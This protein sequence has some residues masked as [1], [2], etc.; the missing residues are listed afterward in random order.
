MNATISVVLVVI[1]SWWTR[2]HVEAAF[3]HSSLSW[4]LRNQVKASEVIG[5]APRATNSALLQSRNEHHDDRNNNN[6]TDKSVEN[7]E[8]PFLNVAIPLVSILALWPL[9]ALFRDTN[10][11]T[12]GFDIDMFM[13]LKGILDEPNQSNLLPEDFV[14][15]P[16][17]SPAE[18]LVD[19]IFGPPP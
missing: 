6:N 10:D 5:G 4:T 7:D 19:A 2:I 1:L 12:F 3:C 14:E 9:L 16:P 18:R 13:A 8:L 17:L 15:L 11:P